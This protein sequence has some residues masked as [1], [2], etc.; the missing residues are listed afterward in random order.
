MSL[1][2]VLGDDKAALPFV[3]ELPP[4][5]TDPYFLPRPTVAVDNHNNNNTAPPTLSRKLIYHVDYVFGV[6]RLY[7]STSVASKVIAIVYG[8]SNPGFARYYKIVSCS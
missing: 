6:H 1:N 8:K 2:D 7:V 4:T 3:Q 5:D